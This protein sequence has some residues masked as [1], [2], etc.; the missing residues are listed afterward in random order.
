MRKPKPGDRVE[1]AKPNFCG[2]SAGKIQTIKTVRDSLTADGITYYDIITE[3]FQQ[4]GSWLASSLTENC[5]TFY[6]L[7]P[8]TD[9]RK[10]KNIEN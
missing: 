3:E 2:I 7:L 4:A 5:T 6:R 9:I 10:R 8:Q 1:V